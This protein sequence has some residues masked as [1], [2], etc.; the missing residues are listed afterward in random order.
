MYFVGVLTNKD[1]MLLVILLLVITPT[2]LNSTH[3]VAGVIT[4]NTTSP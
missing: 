4:R 1:M 2:V 3:P